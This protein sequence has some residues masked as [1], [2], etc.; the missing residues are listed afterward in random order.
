MFKMLFRVDYIVQ[1]KLKPFKIHHGNIT[2]P[3]HHGYKC[4]LF[5]KM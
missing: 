1:R 4:I 5:M 2:P 3:R